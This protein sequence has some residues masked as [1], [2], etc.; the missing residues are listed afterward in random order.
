MSFSPSITESQIMTAVGDW[1][2]SI[3]GIPAEDMVQ[4]HE[5]RVPSPNANYVQMDSILD[6]RLATNDVEYDGVAGTV[7]ETQ[8]TKVGVQLDCF[9]DSANDWARVI[10]T[11]FR[12]SMAYD[13]FESYGIAPLFNDDPRHMP[14]INGENQ[15]ELRW[16]ITLYFQ[17]NVA[18]VAP[19]QFMTSVE[20]G[21]I[22]VDAKYP[23]Q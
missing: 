5:N 3:L 2:C 19:M 7:T 9:G 12:S 13:F 6:T 10:S 8:P 14:V 22:N 4:A 23:Q 21:V 17:C 16:V 1:V 11:I 15:Y 20:I 18:I